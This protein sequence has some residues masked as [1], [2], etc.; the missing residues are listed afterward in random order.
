MEDQNEQIKMEY[1]YSK[2]DDRGTRKYMEDVM[3]TTHEDFPDKIS[4]FAV[5]DG[6]GGKEAA[7]YARSN[8]WKTLKADK[9]LLSQDP[10]IVKT[11]LR[12]AFLKTHNDMWGEIDNW[13]KRKNGMQSTSG[14]TATVAILRGR[15]L[16]VAQVGDSG[17]VLATKNPTTGSTEG[18]LITPEHKPDDPEE[19]RRIRSFG[20]SVAHVNGVSRVVWKR[21]IQKDSASAKKAKHGQKYEYIPFLA[22]SRAL[23]DLWSYDKDTKQYTVS[24]DPYIACH[25][26]RKGEDIFMILASDGLWGVVRPQEA[27]EITTRFEEDQPQNQDA[28][29]NLIRKALTKW[30]GKKL[31]ADNVSAITVFFDQVPGPD[32]NISDPDTVATGPECESEETPPIIFSRGDLPPLK[33]VCAFRA[34]EHLAKRIRAEEI[35]ENTVIVHAASHATGAQSLLNTMFTSENASLVKQ[36]RKSSSTAATPEL[37][38]KRSRTISEGSIADDCTLVTNISTK[39]LDELN[40]DEV[41]GIPQVLPEF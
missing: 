10:E 20:G 26:L 31:K 36:K 9:G 23:G 27:V 1:R 3:H 8:L 4:Y 15:K 13:P 14:T 32:E 38:V 2:S 35:I 28:S 29:G 34:D 39:S 16:Y 6:H 19:E 11:A 17:I 37:A 25:D 21:L 24:P 7:S 41:S 30:K 18:T 5:F 33:R 40:M 22:V 12:N